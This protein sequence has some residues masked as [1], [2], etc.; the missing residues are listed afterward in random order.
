MFG[1]P[2]DPEAE[3]ARDAAYPS[4]WF[5]L[6]LTRE[7]GPLGVIPVRAFGRDL[8]VWRTEDGTAHAANAE[9][10]HYGVHMGR[11][12]KV[13]DGGLQCQIHGLRFDVEGRC[14][15]AHP[16]RPAPSLS[17]RTYPTRE[18]GGAVHVWR[19]PGQ[20]LPAEPGPGMDDAGAALAGRRWRLEASPQ[21]ALAR[22]EAVGA[23]L[24]LYVTPMEAGV[25]QLLA[26]AAGDGALDGLEA[27]LGPP[28]A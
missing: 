22:A 23:Q 24:R 6:A 17:I 18:S 19:D 9:C 2:V 7:L 5:A 4:G 21:D 10:P 25:V 8:V 28:E 12:G 13:R 15:P 27:V 16:G 3:A 14:M 26:L 20:G 1:A 11:G